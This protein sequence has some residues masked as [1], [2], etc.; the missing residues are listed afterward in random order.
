M[1]QEGKVLGRSKKLR[2]LMPSMSA[3][4]QQYP[5]EVYMNAVFKCTMKWKKSKSLY[6]DEILTFCPEWITVG[7]MAQTHYGAF[8]KKLRERI[9]SYY[10]YKKKVQNQLKW[11]LQILL[12]SVTLLRVVKH[13]WWMRHPIA[14]PTHTP[15][16]KWFVEPY[17]CVAWNEK[18]ENTGI[19][20]P[21]IYT[22]PQ[23]ALKNH[24]NMN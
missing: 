11:T 12:S 22:E 6:R 21:S 24:Q 10:K 8:E 18:S 13:Y 4:W 16:K 15:P 3:R 1:K 20:H 9:V 7:W 5:L 2:T 17:S 19:R 23:N 14:S